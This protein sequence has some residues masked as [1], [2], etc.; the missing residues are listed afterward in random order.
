MDGRGKTSGLAFKLLLSAGGLLA[1]ALLA[2]TVVNYRYVSEN[3]VG[4]E[5]R[6]AAQDRIGG[7]ERSIRAAH[8]TDPAAI[9]SVLDDFRDDVADQVASVT[10]LLQSDGTIVASS[11]AAAPSL[12]AEERQRFLADRSAPMAPETRAGRDVLVG[13]FTCR[14]RVAAGEAGPSGRV[15]AEIAI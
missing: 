7:V 11:G 2:Q 13:A 9:Q 10:L 5:A 12:T 1:V 6:R 8:A 14:V 15:V 3:L 4:Q